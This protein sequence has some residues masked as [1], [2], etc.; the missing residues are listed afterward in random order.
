MADLLNQAATKAIRYIQNLDGREVW[1]RQ[2]AVDRLAEFDEPLPDGPAD[3]E[4]VLDFLDALG[5]RRR[6]PLPGRGF[7][8]SCS[9]GAARGA[10]GE[11]AGRRLGPERRPAQRSPVG[12]RIGR[13]CLR[14]LLECWACRRKRRGAS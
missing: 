7:S 2:E 12:S 8:V 5:R 1:P 4:A 11:L 14:W 6:W 13:R 10:G 9:A 3:P